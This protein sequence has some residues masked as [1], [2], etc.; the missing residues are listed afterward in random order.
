MKKYIVTTTINKPTEATLKFCDIAVRDNWVFVIVGDTKTPHEEYFKLQNEHVIYLTP[1]K[2]TEL[3]P[4]LSEIIGWKTIQ[5]RN[6]GFVFAYKNGADIVATVDDDNI[7]YDNWGKDLYVNKEIFVDMYEP[8]LDV[9]DP[10][11]VT[12]DNYIWHRGYPIEYLQQRHLVEYKGKVKRK[13]LVQA[14][15]WDGDPDIDAMARL[16]F[17][18]IVKYSDISKPYCSNKISPFNSQNTFLSRDVIPFYSVF[19]FTGR[20]DDIW[21]AYILQH[22]FPNS[23]IYSPASVYQDRNVQD[24]I[25]NLEKEIIGYR[26][27]LKLIHNLK[28][29]ESILPQE[30]I[31]YF[32]IYRKQFN[33]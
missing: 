17:K 1:E 8:K 2:Q 22:Y 28:D 26:N 31:E 21:G 9:F 3:Y 16:T 10:L 24:L 11:S 6:I 27:T 14:D 18:P 13:I 32:N 25:T 12:K 15:L 30:S 5:R 20:M 7:P 4:E 33:L 19:P 23:V 29:Y